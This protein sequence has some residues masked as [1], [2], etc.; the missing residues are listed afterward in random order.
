MEET[1]TADQGDRRERR[2][3]ENGMAHR[4][5]HATRRRA[6]HRPHQPQLAQRPAE[7]AG[8]DHPHAGRIRPVRHV[9]LGRH[10]GHPI[11]RRREQASAERQAHHGEELRPVHPGE[12]TLPGRTVGLAVHHPR[13]THPADPQLRRRADHGSRR[14]ENRPAATRLHAARNRRRLCAARP[15]AA[16]PASQ[17]HRPRTR[18][19]RDGDPHH[20]VRQRAR[21]TRRDQRAAPPA[22]HPRP[23]HRLPGAHRRAPLHSR[24]HHHRLLHAGRPQ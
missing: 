23:R 16:R 1:R 2:P 18:T 11:V 7:R 14:L 20:S 17:I 12:P 4:T 21:L 15:D 8:H 3:E 13:Q 22:T 9:P 10:P 24:H 5:H 19:R 6:G